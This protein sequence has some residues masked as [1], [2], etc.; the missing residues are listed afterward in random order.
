MLRTRFR[1]A[2]AASALALALIGGAAGTTAAS[3]A[4]LTQVPLHN[5]TAKEGECPAAALPGVKYWHFVSTPNNASSI[6]TITLNINGQITSV[7]DWIK[8]PR[9]S[10]A[11]VAVPAG[12][13]W[14]SLRLPYSSFGVTGTTDAVKLSHTCTGGG[15]LVEKLE[16]SKTAVTTYDRAHHWSVDKSVDQSALKLYTNGSG[17]TTVNYTVDVGYEGSTDSGWNVS[18]AVVIKNTGDLPAT[19]ESIVDTMTLGDAVN[20]VALSCDGDLELALGETL[21]CTYSQDVAG[22]VDGTNAAVVTTGTKSYSG[23][24]DVVWGAPANEADQSVT[25]T[26]V[27][28][29]TGTQAKSFR[30]PYGGQL[31]YSKA[32]SYADYGQARCGT[33]G[34]GN[35][36][37]LTGDDDE[38]L[39][40]ANADV[41][42]N[43]QCMVMGNGET[44]W[45][46]GTKYAGQNSWAM[47]ATYGDGATVDLMAGQHH[48]AGDVTFTDLG[49]GKVQ[50]TIALDGWGF[51]AVK[52]NLKIQGYASAP[53]PG[54]VAPGQ[55]KTYKGTVSS[56]AS[57]VS[58]TVD[59]FAYYGIHADVGKWIP[60]P[61]F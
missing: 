54:K 55:F 39:G 43:V 44:A 41:T 9:S 59:K 1:A 33:H 28:D 20:D 40:S 32:L 15:A 21:T 14:D 27:G 52:E 38:V 58:V 34:Y 60:D 25:L 6:E 7:T 57:T 5:A 12:L 24:A 3:A 30:A 26:D 45:A 11:Y 56:D 2:V 46:Q 49:N 37:T 16:V 17:D 53:A 18:G 8:H 4:D 48:D 36:A 29:L 19:I 50:I 31:T 35:V 10:H 23:S 51:R 47:Y 61:N 42:V 22:A 13:S